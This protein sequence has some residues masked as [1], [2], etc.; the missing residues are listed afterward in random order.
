MWKWIKKIYKKKHECEC[1]DKHEDENGE[2]VPCFCEC[3]LSEDEKNK[4]PFNL[5]DMLN[6]PKF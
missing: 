3:H 4:E 6:C 1:W 5:G 2:Y